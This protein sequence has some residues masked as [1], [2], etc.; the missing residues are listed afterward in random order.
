MKTVDYDP[1]IHG[2]GYS[3]I[4]PMEVVPPIS[5]DIVLHKEGG[6]FLK[7]KDAPQG[8]WAGPRSSEH[9]YDG[10][11]LAPTKAETP[12][13]YYKFLDSNGRFNV[14]GALPSDGH[15]NLSGIKANPTM[16]RALI[17]FIQDALDGE[18]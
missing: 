9:H 3:K 10:W 17:D 14:S 4:V 16:A 1:A 2:D 18:G 13:S 6:L 11:T 15:I 12:K 7:R 5:S 8:E